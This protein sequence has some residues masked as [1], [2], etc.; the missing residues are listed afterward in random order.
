M[1]VYKL[2]L[3]DKTKGYELIAILIERTK[4][5]KRIIKDSVI[6]RGEPFW[7]MMEKGKVSFSRE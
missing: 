5:E 4:K 1:L 2:Y 6:N 7:M 3:F